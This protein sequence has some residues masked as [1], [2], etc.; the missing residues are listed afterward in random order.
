MLFRSPGESVGFVGSNGAGKSTLLKIISGVMF[1]HSGRVTVQGRI[2][3]LIEVSSGIHP[4]L[5]GKENISVF[6]TLLGELKNYGDQGD[7]YRSGP[8]VK[9]GMMDLVARIMTSSLP[10]GLVPGSKSVLVPVPASAPSAD[11]PG[12]F[13]FATKSGDNFCRLVVG[14]A[15]ELSRV[16]NLWHVL[17]PLKVLLVVLIVSQHLQKSQQFRWGQPLYFL[18]SYVESIVWLAFHNNSCYCNNNAA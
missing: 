4:E 2:G 14:G 17:L 12:E 9:L 5:T 10:K 8:K 18:M 3:A 11:Q 16:A 13:R 1:P 6:G 15:A 7:R